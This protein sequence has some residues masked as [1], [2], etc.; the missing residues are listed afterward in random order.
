MRNIFLY[1]TY[2]EHRLE[3]WRNAIVQSDTKLFTFYWA[4]YTIV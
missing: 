1:D 4:D 3:T 2:M